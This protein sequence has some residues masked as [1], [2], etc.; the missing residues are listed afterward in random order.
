MP[1]LP[2]AFSSLRMAISLLQQLHP[3]LFAII[4]TH[5]SSNY[6][7]RD[8]YYRIRLRRDCHLAT[9]LVSLDAPITRFNAESRRVQTTSIYRGKGVLTIMIVWMQVN[10]APMPS[11]A[12]KPT[13]I[14]ASS[15]PEPFIHVEAYENQGYVRSAKAS[16]LPKVSQLLADSMHSSTLSTSM[17][18]DYQSLPNLPTTI[19]TSVQREHDETRAIRQDQKQRSE[20]DCF[21]VSDGCRSCKIL[22]FLLKF[23]VSMSSIST[24]PSSIISCFVLAPRH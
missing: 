21:G 14:S 15:N 22:F 11:F 4:F 12:I 6:L 2:P 1:A 18:P 5:S 17:M 20:Q 23:G 10:T 3:I 8:E 16:L 7:V 13:R 9:G 24:V 19:V